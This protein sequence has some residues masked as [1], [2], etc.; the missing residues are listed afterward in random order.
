MGFI[1]A[2]MKKFQILNPKLLDKLTERLKIK[3][4]KNIETLAEEVVIVDSTSIIK[5]D[6]IIEAF[7]GDWKLL[8]K[9]ILGDLETILEKSSIIYQNLRPDNS[10]TLSQR[11]V[12]IKNREALRNK[13]KE[14][15]PASKE[16]KETNQNIMDHIDEENNISPDLTD[17]L[18]N[19]L[20][21]DQIKGFLDLINHL[22]SNNLIDQF[23]QLAESQSA[24][25]SKRTV[26]KLSSIQLTSDEIE[27]LI[28]HIQNKLEDMN[29]HPK[30]KELDFVFEIQKIFAENLNPKSQQNSGNPLISLS[31][32]DKSTARN[33]YGLINMMGLK[34]SKEQDG[35]AKNQ[36]E[37]SSN[38]PFQPP[39]AEKIQKS[40]S[41]DKPL[42]QSVPVML[43]SQKNDSS[44]A[45]NENESTDQETDVLINL[46]NDS[47]NL[48]KFKQ[49]QESYRSI[50]QFV[51][52]YDQ[53]AALVQINPNIEIENQ[54]NEEIRENPENQNVTTVPTQE[55]NSQSESNIKIAAWLL[56]GSCATVGGA[57]IIIM[58]NFLGAFCIAAALLTK[59][60]MK[61]SKTQSNQDQTENVFGKKQSFFDHQLEKN[62]SLHSNEVEVN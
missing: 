19:N 22:L 13:L 54:T 43:T 7:T 48:Q 11:S 9:D 27:P 35:L 17:N 39:N 57:M 10:L 14:K 30:Q 61:A 58:G 34:V 49:E 44:H 52:N 38:N 4:E 23:D 50:Q 24:E 2:I 45:N 33:L 60:A 51:S 59:A 5:S 18:I 53:Q 29:Y 37:I 46:Q 56:S 12:I 26:K 32:Q 8:G 16:N 55:Q 36:I 41:I 20:T 21:E 42:S 25:E 28:K 31:E 1:K 40:T 6:I 62:F 3:L 47:S 15:L